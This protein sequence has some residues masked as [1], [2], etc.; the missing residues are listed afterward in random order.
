MDDHRAIV[1]FQAVHKWFGPLHVLKDI[2]LEITKGECVVL[3]GPSGSGKS[4]L[5]YCI[6]GLAPYEQGSVLVN[7]IKISERDGTAHDVRKS[8]GMIF[9]RYNLFPHLSVMENCMLGPMTVL[10]E[11]DNV[12][13]ERAEQFLA[14]VNMLGHASK[15]PDTLSGGQQ[16]RVA[17]AR[18][19]C[20]QPEILIMDEPTS[21][22]D[23][24]MV[25]E[26]LDVMSDLARS[27]IT[28]V[29]VTHEMGF[30]RRIA[31]RIVFMEAGRIITVRPPAEFFD[32]DLQD[33]RVSTFLSQVLH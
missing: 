22:L 29:A 33:D 21:A 26:V 12:A 23:P 1:Q 2:N 8:V 5:S 7:G 31:S 24:E 13:R 19:L 30:A 14:R 28:I 32:P 16:Q 10:G 20:M 9:Q 18:A 11:N 15:Y 3:C 25:G 27:G 17:I 6:N 4:T